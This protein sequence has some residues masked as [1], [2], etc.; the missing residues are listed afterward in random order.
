MQELIN[1]KM[2]KIAVIGLGYVGLPLAVEFGRKRLVIGFDINETRVKELKK[3]TDTTLEVNRQE[4]KKA[5]FLSYT[6][7]INDLKV[8]NI[9]IITVPTPIDR[10][11]SYL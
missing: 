8:C 3:G 5:V 2:S 9:Y 11:K 1:L 4:L 10:H 6:T 7:N